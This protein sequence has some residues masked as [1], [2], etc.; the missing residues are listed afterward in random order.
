V[1]A[2]VKDTLRAIDRWEGKGILSQPLAVSLRAEVESEGWSE[3]RRWSQYLLAAT[4]GAVLLI[5]AGTFLAWVL[6]ELGF[7]GQAITLALAGVVILALGIGFT[8]WAR[9]RPVA[10][11]LQVAGPI[12]IVMAAAWSENAWPDRSLQAV[13]AALVVMIAAVAALAVAVRK[14]D[15]LVALQAPL[16]FLYLFGALDRALGLDTNVILWALD[17]LLVVALAITGFRL[18]KPGGPVWLLGAFA[19][20][21]YSSLVLMLFSSLV[22]WDMDRFA[23]IPLDI[24]L[25]AVGGLSVWGLQGSVPEHLRND[26]YERQLAY[27]ILLW[28]P[29]GFFTTLEAMRARTWQR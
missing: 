4:G 8:A 20:F 14:D 15:L 21:L 11:F 27:V 5:A 28:I 7:G 6:P 25:L 17:G 2:S 18:R 24:W 3:S 1:S 12:M 16:F 10:Y 23:V 19:A 9:W 29:F 26:A 22:I 13:A